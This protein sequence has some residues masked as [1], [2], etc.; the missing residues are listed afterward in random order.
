MI[1]VSDNSVLSCLAELGE[2]DL[3][4]RLYGKITLTGTAGLFADAAAAGWID[5]ED[6]LLRLS[7]TGFRLGTEIVESLRAEQG[8]LR[9]PASD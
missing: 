2:L 6:A 5:F 9:P 8:K 1:V 3:L 4:R 7:H